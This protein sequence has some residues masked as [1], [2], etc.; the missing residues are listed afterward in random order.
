MNPLWVIAIVVAIMAIGTR[1]FWRGLRLV[2]SAA[3]VVILS[4]RVGVGLVLAG[5]WVWRGGSH[6]WCSDRT[7]QNLPAVSLDE[8][9]AVLERLPANASPQAIDAA[10]RTDKQRRSGCWAKPWPAR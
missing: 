5:R 2:V 10:V 3:L 1:V 8:F 9:K 7:A 4:V 6:G